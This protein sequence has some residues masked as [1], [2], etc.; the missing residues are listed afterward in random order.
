MVGLVALLAPFLVHPVAAKELRGRTV[1][2]AYDGRDIGHPERA[3]RARAY[4]VPEAAKADAP[5]PLLI[6]L[7]GLNRALVH[8]RWIGSE[9]DGD[10]RRIVGEL[11]AAGRVAPLVV[12]APS[13]TVASQ[14][15]RHASWNHFDVDHF[16]QQTERALGDRLRIDTTRIVVAGHSGAGCSRAGGLSAAALGKRKLWALLAIDTCMA[17]WLAQDLASAPASTHVV[18]TYQPY[19]WTRDHKLFSRV[20]EREVDKAPA[21]QGVLRRIDRLEPERKKGHNPHD[22]TVPMTLERWLPKLLP[23]G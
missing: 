8:H 16:I 10:L 19:S 15:M 4:A 23:A 12:A 5:V 18:V 20:F 21:T 9:H 6:F 14:V 13:S 1:D 2:Y 17:P 22:D 7:H 3:W 11:V